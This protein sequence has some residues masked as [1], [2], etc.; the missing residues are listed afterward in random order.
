MP[1]VE[2]F[3]PKGAIFGEARAEVAEALVVGDGG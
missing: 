3:T 2:V 1:F